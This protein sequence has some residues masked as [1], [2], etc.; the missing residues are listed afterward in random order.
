MNCEHAHRTIRK[1]ETALQIKQET[2]D[3]EK[4]VNNYLEL[5]EEQVDENNTLSKEIKELQVEKFLCRL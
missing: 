2:L 3:E 4:T 1:L 5:Y